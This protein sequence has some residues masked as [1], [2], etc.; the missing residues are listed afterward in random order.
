MAQTEELNPFTHPDPLTF[1]EH[2]NLWNA[3]Q[4]AR[5]RIKAALLLAA[6]FA[7]ALFVFSIMTALDD[8]HQRA[9]LAGAERR[10]LAAN[11]RALKMIDYLNSLKK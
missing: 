7:G 4:S 10:V 8:S 11:I 1:H 6:L 3:Y 9:E 5:E 2:L